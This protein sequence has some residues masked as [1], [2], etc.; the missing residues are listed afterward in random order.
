M[1]LWVAAPLLVAMAVT[2]SHAGESNGA[3]ELPER[4]HPVDVVLPEGMI[5]PEGWPLSDKNTLTC[6][7]CHG[8]DDIDQ[9]DTWADLDKRDPRFLH[10]GP[11]R[12]QEQFCFRCHDDTG[13]QRW[14][15]HRQKL[16]NGKLD[17]RSCSYCHLEQ[18]QQ[19]KGEV[20]QKTDLRLPPAV[21]CLGCH[22]KTPHLNSLEHAGAPSE[23]VLDRLQAHNRSARRP[24]PLDEQQHVTCVTCHDPHQP[25]VIEKLS[26][27]QEVWLG[28]SDVETGSVYVSS[29]WSPVYEAD[30]AERLADL[31]QHSDWPLALRYRRLEQEVLLRLPAKDGT[32]CNACHQFE[33]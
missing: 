11:Y 15:L 4:H 14:N 12:R 3:T 32:L 5:L 33:D 19:I 10:D 30:K 27:D 28:E 6:A 7:S 31:Q 1:T 20:P 29:R 24:L 13:Y 26:A 9:P 17:E 22:L 21:L 2:V 18:P 25:G 23:K 8:L 16:D